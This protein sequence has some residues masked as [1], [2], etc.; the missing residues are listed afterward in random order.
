[1][2]RGTSFNST[3]LRHGALLSSLST[4]KQAACL[5]SALWCCIPW[6]ASDMGCYPP[7]HRTGHDL[8]M[9]VLNVAAACLQCPLHMTAEQQS[10]AWLSLECAWVCHCLRCF[11]GDTG[12]FRLAFAIAHKSSEFSQLTVQPAAAL[13][14]RP[15]KPS[16]HHRVRRSLCVNSSSNFLN[17]NLDCG[18]AFSLGNLQ[19]QYDLAVS[20]G[21][22][23]RRA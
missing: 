23:S 13:D 8:C 12:T 5:L 20:A 7:G 17:F 3:Y 22:L 11:W 6:N 10:H 16:D 4:W 1:M 15:A 2:Y 9:P 19:A 21:R 18:A 14:E